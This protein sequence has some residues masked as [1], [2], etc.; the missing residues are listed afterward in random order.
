MKTLLQIT[1]RS[2]CASSQKSQLTSTPTIIFNSD[3]FNQDSPMIDSKHRKKQQNNNVNE[4]TK[5]T[6]SDTSNQM[7]ESTLTQYFQMATVNKSFD[8]S[9]INEVEFQNFI[10]IIDYLSLYFSI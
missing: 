4:L 9:K 8:L 2:S 1:D 10:K 6:F 3:S 7:I 5:T